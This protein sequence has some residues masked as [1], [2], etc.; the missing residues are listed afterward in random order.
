[1]VLIAIVFAYAM[2]KFITKSLKSISDKM[3]QTRFEKRNKKIALEGA[4]SEIMSL[5]ES[6]NNMIDALED[7]ALK[8][9]STEREEAWREMAK[10]VAHEIKNPPY[11]DALKRTGFSAENL[12]LKT[13]IFM[14]KLRNIATH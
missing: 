14:K 6:Y 12:T 2:S 10:Q 8:L 11:T 7:S 13:K 1:M 5:V 9:A 3:Y 4:S